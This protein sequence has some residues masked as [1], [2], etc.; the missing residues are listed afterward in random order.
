[1]FSFQ[2]YLGAWLVYIVCVVGLLAV[3]WRITKHLPWFYLKQCLRLTVASL[4]LVPAVVEGNTLYWAPAWIKGL[5]SLIFSGGEGFWPIGKLLLIAVIASF[6]IYLLLL[7][8]QH[9]Y[10]QRSQAKTTPSN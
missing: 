7:I 10:R 1:M 3:F 2:E 4:L 6:I 9:F 5:L 8:I